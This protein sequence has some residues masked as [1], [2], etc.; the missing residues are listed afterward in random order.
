METR[1]H[2]FR[3]R[4]T[5][6]DYIVTRALLVLAALLYPATTLAPKV[7]DAITGRPLRWHNL[8][9]EP[10]PAAEVG[11]SDGV[12]VHYAAALDWAIANPTPGQMLGALLSPLI[13]TGLTVTGVVIVWRLLGVVQAGEPFTADTVRSLRILSILVVAYAIAA[14]FSRFLGDV[15][16]TWPVLDPPASYFQPSVT[17]G[18]AFII[19]LLMFALTEAFSRGLELRRETEGLI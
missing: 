16:V 14:P 18:A 1:Q 17:N 10:G 4:F 11:V 9:G 5:R 3:L 8:A 2:P 15:L 12:T 7:W 13:V 19:G 6:A